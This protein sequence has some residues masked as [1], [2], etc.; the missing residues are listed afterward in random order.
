MYYNF[1]KNPVSSA[2][3]VWNYSSSIVDHIKWTPK[4]VLHIKMIIN[5]E[6]LRTTNDLK[7]SVCVELNN[8]YISNTNQSVNVELYNDTSQ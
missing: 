1:I 2:S 5:R 8:A 7:Q 6:I 4:K 3:D